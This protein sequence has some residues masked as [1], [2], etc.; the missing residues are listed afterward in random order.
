MS[1]LPTDALRDLEQ[2]YAAGFGSPLPENPQAP[3]ARNKKPRGLVNRKTAVR[4]LKDIL[5]SDAAS[6]PTDILRLIYMV[7]M[8]ELQKR[9]RIDAVDGMAISTAFRGL[10]Y[11][12]HEFSNRLDSYYAELMSQD[13]SSLFS[14]RDE[15]VFYVYAHYRPTGKKV[16]IEHETHPL[17][18]DGLPFYIGK[19]TGAR[20]FEMKRNQGHGA[21]MRSIADRGASAGDLAVILFDGL[22]EAKALEIESKL[23]YLFGTKYEEGRKGMLVNLEIPAR[24]KMEYLSSGQQKKAKRAARCATN[25]PQG[26]QPVVHYTP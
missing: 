8:K 12:H 13:W 2:A 16:K 6:V 4:S 17:V 21:T 14:G 20:A 11:P 25:T 9:R 24:P 7:A 1:H 26:Q 10:P 3:D 22:S 23:I 15:P 5:E 19:G 18:I